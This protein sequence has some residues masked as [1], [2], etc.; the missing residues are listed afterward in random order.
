M[1]LFIRCKGRAVTQRVI[2]QYISCYC[3]SPI[4]IYNIYYKCI[5]QYISCYC[6]SNP[7]AGGW[8]YVDYFNTSH[9]T[10]YHKRCWSESRRS[11][12]YFNTSHV[13]VYQQ[14][15]YCIR[16]FC[17]ISI[18]LMLLFINA[19]KQ[20]VKVQTS[21]QYISC[22]CLSTWFESI[23]NKLDGFQY[24]SCYCLSEK[25]QLPDIDIDLFQYISCYCLSNELTPFYIF[26]RI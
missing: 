1:L 17:F 21:F 9:V 26:L 14:N 5:F 7:G 16:S 10:V 11:N 25:K 3:L 19:T 6:L 15:S 23:K 4:I 2:F 20:G 24:I 22:Y 8:C 12:D 13:T 18:H